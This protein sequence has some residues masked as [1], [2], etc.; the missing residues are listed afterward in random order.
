MTS[1]ASGVAGSIIPIVG[2]GIGLGLLAHTARN[3]SDI[4]YKPYRKR[5]YKSKKRRYQPPL[6]IKPYTPRRKYRW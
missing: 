3:V 2:A 5:R 6:V 1:S 4:M